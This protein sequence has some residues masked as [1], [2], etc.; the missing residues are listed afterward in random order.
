MTDL[1]PTLP[2]VL[3]ELLPTPEVLLAWNR[4]SWSVCSR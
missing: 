4:A 1:A 3:A 2:A